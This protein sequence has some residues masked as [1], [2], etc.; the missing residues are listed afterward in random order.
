M[1]YPRRFGRVVRRVVRRRPRRRRIL[2]ARRFRRPRPGRGN[3]RVKLTK[4]VTVAH[5]ADSTQMFSLGVQPKDFTEFLN[6]APNFE[7]YRM[8]KMLVRIVPQANVSNNTTSANGV[9]CLLPWHQPTPS[10]EN[11]FNSFLSVDRAKVYRGT[12]RGKQIYN[13]NVLQ[14]MNY[15]S[16]D[17]ERVLWSPR[18]EIRNDSAYETRHFS[19]LFIMN[20]IEGKTKEDVYRYDVIQDVWI[21]FYNQD[22]IKE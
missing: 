19:G 1:R 22:V 13:M 21:E 10:V 8:K 20:R 16:T 15:D 18:I 4:I 9:Y 17:L 2:R 14:G 5:T 12:E 3:F 11:S 7:A 6:L